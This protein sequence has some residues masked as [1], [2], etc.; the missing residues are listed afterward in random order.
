MTQTEMA[1]QQPGEKINAI[2]GINADNAIN[3]FKAKKKLMRD[4]TELMQN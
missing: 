2:D 1:K 4:N 3:D